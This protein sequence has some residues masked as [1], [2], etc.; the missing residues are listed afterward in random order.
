MTA[1]P[2]TGWQAELVGDPEVTRAGRLAIPL[3]ITRNGRPMARLSLVLNGSQ[4]SNLRHAFERHL[5]GDD[6]GAT[7]SAQSEP[8]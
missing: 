6:A 5:R 2:N 8:S 4:I 3:T 1:N 7:P